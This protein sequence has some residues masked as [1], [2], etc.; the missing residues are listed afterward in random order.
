MENSRLFLRPSSFL[1][2]TQIRREPKAERGCPPALFCG[3]LV[4]T[5]EERPPASPLLWYIF[6]TS[7]KRLPASPLLW[8]TRPHFGREAVRLPSF[9][10]YSSS[11]QERGSPPALFCGILVLTSGE[12]PPASPLLWYTRPHF[13][14][15][16]ARQPSFVVYSS[17]LREKGGALCP[18]DV[19]DEPD[20]AS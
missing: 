18:K 17:S 5:S 6:L 13:G 3:I 11:L 7:G 9:V 15:E 10:V 4:L 19:A 8:Y 2:S 16:A 14:R 20:W 12:R 1:R